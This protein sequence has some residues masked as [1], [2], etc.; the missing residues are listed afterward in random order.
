MNLR[1]FLFYSGMT[2]RELA[3]DLGFSHSHIRQILCGNHT[4]SKPFGV[5]IEMYTKG[6]VKKDKVMGPFTHPEFKDLLRHKF[7]K[8]AVEV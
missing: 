2:A 7:V 5:T 6:I 3:A 4:I 8:G 1:E